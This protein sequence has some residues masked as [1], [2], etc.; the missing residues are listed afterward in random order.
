MASGLDETRHVA[1]MN[2]LDEVMKEDEAED[3][4]GQTFRERR[5]TYT[6]HNLA[7]AAAAAAA[8]DN[9]DDD[10][11]DDNNNEGN[12]SLEDIP[13]EASFR[14]RRLSCATL[15]VSAAAAATAVALNDSGDDDTNDEEQNQIGKDGVVD[16]SLK[17]KRDCD[18]EK[19]PS[20]EMKRFKSR[21]VHASLPAQHSNQNSKLYRHV[22]PNPANNHYHRPSNQSTTHQ[23]LKNDQPEWKQ[24]HHATPDHDLPFPRHVVGTYS[25]HGVEPLYD[26]SSSDNEEH[27]QSKSIAKIN[28]DR[29]GVAYPYG[30]CPRTA[31]LAAYDGH[32]DGGELVAQYALH[33]VQSLLE[34]H[35]CFKSNIQK[36]MIQTFLQVDESLKDEKEIEPWYSGC[37]AIVTLVREKQLIVANCGDSR[38]VLATKDSDGQRLKAVDLSHDQ[39]PDTPGEKERILSRGGYVSPPPEEGLSARVWLDPSF[40]QIGLAMARSVGDHAV[41]TVGVIAKPEVKIYDIDTEN[42]EFVIIATDGVWEFISSQEAVDIVQKHFVNKKEESCCASKACQDLIETAAAKWHQYEGD[43]RDDITALVVR[44]NKL[45]GYMDKMEQQHPEK[46]STAAIESPSSGISSGPGT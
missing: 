28:Q 3:D 4:R 31:L 42:D 12:V 38:A 30:N 10:D 9:E 14:E 24:R 46:S 13:E 45:W 11:A 20:N 6:S 1:D 29:G 22:V 43:Y 35:P 44:I 41:K 25:C 16:G 26:S 15:D 39:N 7:A 21:V 40:T 27:Q 23:Q 17:R 19:N 37:T 2:T 34:K 8:L 5:L 33:Q 32:G 36:A 18:E